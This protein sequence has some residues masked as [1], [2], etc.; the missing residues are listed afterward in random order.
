MGMLS[1]PHP[2]KGGV[3]WRFEQRWIKGIHVY[4]GIDPGIFEPYMESFQF[5]GLQGHEVV[6]LLNLFL[7]I[8]KDRGGSIDTFEM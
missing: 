7:R 6:R 4:K 1:A 5:L 3:L 8:D 2:R